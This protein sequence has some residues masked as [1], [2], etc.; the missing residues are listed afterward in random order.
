MKFDGVWSICLLLFFSIFGSLCFWS[1]KWLTK[2][3]HD[4]AWLLSCRSLILLCS[5]WVP[6]ARHWSRRMTKNWVTPSHSQF[7]KR[8]TSD[9]GE[10]LCLRR[11]GSAWLCVRETLSFLPC[12]SFSQC[13]CPVVLGVYIAWCGLGEHRP[14]AKPLRSL[15][16]VSPKLLPPPFCSHC[17]VAHMAWHVTVM[18][19]EWH[20]VAVLPRITWY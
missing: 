3:D 20:T 13:W 14:H 11:M 5:R 19:Q 8:L 17:A 12:S 16:P 7:P 10:D 2:R 15:A 9:P 1:E 18:C 6:G 4:S